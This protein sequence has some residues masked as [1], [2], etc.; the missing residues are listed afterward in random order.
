MRPEVLWIQQLRRRSSVNNIRSTLAIVW[1]IAG[2]YFRSED[3]W[4]GRLLLGSVIAIELSLVAIS[5]LVNQWNNRF[6]TA[7]QERNWD[8]FIREIGI[9]TI[10]A[11]CSIA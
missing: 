10:L 1:R 6:Y 2:P 9:F 7:L 5:V 4:P 11:F 8:N 3:K